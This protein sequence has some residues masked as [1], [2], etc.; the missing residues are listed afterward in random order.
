MVS[1]AMPPLVNAALFATL[2]GKDGLDIKDNTDD[3]IAAAPGGARNQRTYEVAANP[4]FDPK[5]DFTKDWYMVT[6]FPYPVLR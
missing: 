4:D 1:E 3:P 6:T 2:A 5:W